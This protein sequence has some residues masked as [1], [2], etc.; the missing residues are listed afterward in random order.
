[1]PTETS[2][3]AEKAAA[4]MVKLINNG[5]WN[6]K[7]Q[8]PDKGQQFKLYPYV[9]K[10]MKSEHD[11][12]VSLGTLR[13]I[14][15]KL[16]GDPYRTGDDRA[17]PDWYEEEWSDINDTIAAWNSRPGPQPS[18]PSTAPQQCR[19]CES[20]RSVRDLTRS[21]FVRKSSSLLVE[22]AEHVDLCDAQ[23]EFVATRLHLEFLQRQLA[24]LSWL[25]LQEWEVLL[26]EAP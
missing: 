6:G 19:I 13:R 26:K 3:L 4:L 18:E 20:L 8:L 1:M 12:K 16:R 7:R 25:V 5:H 17:V 11:W 2:D 15:A 23:D 9:Q 22:I 14:M 10:M 24:A 21:E